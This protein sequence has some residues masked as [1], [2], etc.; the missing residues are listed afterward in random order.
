MKSWSAKYGNQLQL[1]EEAS[2]FDVFVVGTQAA[3]NMASAHAFEILH[4]NSDR[5]AVPTQ[6]N[7]S[8]AESRQ[9]RA[10]LSAIARA[11]QIVAPES[12]I[13]VICRLENVVEALS[14]RR[15]LRTNADIWSEIS[16][17]RES[18][19]IQLS[20]IRAPNYGREDFILQGL[21][22]KARAAL[23]LALGVLQ[24]K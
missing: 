10:C 7:V 20:A 16:A 13:R 24:A 1:V 11:L 18:K 21:L 3:N 19:S 14:G 5:A 2:W 22:Q 9:E 17:L 6:V 15:K 23:A 8:E 4:V 12:H